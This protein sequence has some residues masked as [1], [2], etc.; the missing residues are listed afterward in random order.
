MSLKVLSEVAQPK[1]RFAKTT[2]G[3]MLLIAVL[4]ILAN[5]AYVCR[6]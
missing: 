3:T 5:V 6:I 4:F 2:I 1:K